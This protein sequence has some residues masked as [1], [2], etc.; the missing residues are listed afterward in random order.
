MS[1]FSELQAVVDGLR[2]SKD[3]LAGLSEVEKTAK[4]RND[5]FQKLW[6]GEGVDP[7]FKNEEQE[8]FL[9]R[10]ISDDDYFQTWRHP[11]MIEMM[12][13]VDA[14][15]ALRLAWTVDQRCDLL[16]QFIKNEDLFSFLF[17][18]SRPFR[19]EGLLAMINHLKKESISE[20]YWELVSSVWID[21]EDPCVFSSN[22][23]VWKLLW[24]NSHRLTNESVTH[25]DTD[26]EK[27]DSL[28]DTI[29]I[30]RAGELSGLSWTTS[31]KTAEFFKKRR[32]RDCQLWS[33]KIK[34]S[35]IVWFTDDRGESEIVVIDVTTLQDISKVA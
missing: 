11:L 20:H 28:P 30:Y 26:K 31:I 5:L 25:L 9:L 24:G 14:R 34:K 15:T 7:D 13:G 1:K 6:I 16:E 8:D 21:S 23:D 27:F 35:D 3:V 33:A 32:D 4:D 10:Y 2:P 19:L 22:I 12:A 17:S 29:V 18:Y